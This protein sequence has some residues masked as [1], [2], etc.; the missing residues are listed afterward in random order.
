[1]AISPNPNPDSEA[2]AERI[3]ESIRAERDSVH[4]FLAA[5]QERLEKAEA[6]V[7]EL[8]EQYEGTGAPAAG[9]AAQSDTEHDYQRRYEMALDDLHDLKASNALLQEQ[10]AKARSAA[11]TAAKQNPTQDTQ[12]DWETQKKRMLAALESDSDEQ[13]AEQH[14]ERLK[15]E[16]AL[17]IT[18]NVVADKDAEIQALKRQL[19]ESANGAGAVAVA[20][21]ALADVIDND[22]AIREERTRLQQLQ[23]QMKSKMCQAEI[24][25]SLERAKLARDRVHLEE[26]MQSL[27]A[28]AQKTPPAPGAAE[29]TEPARSRWMSR[30]GL[31]DADRERG[32]H[33]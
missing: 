14:T 12:L 20:A 2:W 5:Q 23:E 4:D 21:A 19:E 30:L 8:L 6:A 26:Q 27:Q 29:T 9:D 17:R 10:L 13:N 32:R 33:G 3:A 1:M 16:D 24:E 31:T 28:N 15:I 7:Q 11:V 22:T 25:L 18:E